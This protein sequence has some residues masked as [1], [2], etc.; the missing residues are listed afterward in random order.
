MLW[1]GF[2][3]VDVLISKKKSQ[4]LLLLRSTFSSL[5][6]STENMP[7]AAC[8][9]ASCSRTREAER[10]R[11][12]ANV[13]FCMQTE[14]THV[15]SMNPRHAYP[16]GPP[17][18]CLYLSWSPAS[19]LL[20]HPY[21]HE[22][23]HTTECGP[24]LRLKW[25]T[26]LPMK[27]DVCECACMCASMFML[28]FPAEWNIRLRPS[29]AMRG[30]ELWPQHT[31]A[32]NSCFLCDCMGACT[33]SHM[34][35]RRSSISH[36]SGRAGVYGLAGCWGLQGYVCAALMGFLAPR[37]GTQHVLKIVKD[38]SQN[39]KLCVIPHSWSHYALS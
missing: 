8:C 1:A 19:L 18:G 6:N 38:W 2:N 22:Y 10:E 16:N 24:K 25:M 31:H 26:D 13:P 14:F 23:R 11:D 34:H 5:W 28:V 9:V 3:S 17:T 36:I 27:I 39:S 37:L 15:N 29:P 12:Q 33:L 20:W 21:I 30:R 32:H 7:G 4:L 35:M